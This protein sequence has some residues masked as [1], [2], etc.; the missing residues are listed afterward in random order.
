M[1]QREV[2]IVK[3]IIVVT[4]L[5]SSV[6]IHHIYAMQCSIYSSVGLQNLSLKCEGEYEYVAKNY[7]I[8]PVALAGYFGR[9]D[10]ERTER[11]DHKMLITV[12]E[13][14]T[15]PEIYQAVVQSVVKSIY[16]LQHKDIEPNLTY[17]YFQQNEESDQKI[18]KSDTKNGYDSSLMYQEKKD[19]LVSTYS[20]AFLMTVL[21]SLMYVGIYDYM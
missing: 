2:S 20:I 5:C 11:I 1:I 6:S 4:M 9:I 8:Q 21:C 13:W 7:R 17:M 19:S 15:K 16:L 14:Y 10:D 3:G 12:W 18:K